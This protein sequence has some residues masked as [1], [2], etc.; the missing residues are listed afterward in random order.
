[1]GVILSNNSIEF[2]RSL[3]SRIL[4]STARH[5]V[6]TPYRF[7]DEVSF[8]NMNVFELRARNQY[9]MLKSVQ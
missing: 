3:H 5:Q 6:K 4:Q 7:E 2:F 8:T 9:E 1:M